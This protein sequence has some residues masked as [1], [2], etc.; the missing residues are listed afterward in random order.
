MGAQVGIDIEW[1]DR[2][3]DLGPL[4]ERIFNAADL[5]H[6]RALPEAAKP[7]AFFRAWTGKEAVLKAKGLGLFGGVQEISVPLDDQPAT[8]RDGETSWQ[9]EPVVMPDGYLGSVAHN[10]AR[11]PLRVRRIDAI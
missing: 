11:K 7:R 4:A 2:R 8:L 1:L 6:F 10:E 9:V 3:V 5:A